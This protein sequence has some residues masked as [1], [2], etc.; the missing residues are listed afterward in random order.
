[1]RYSV[2]SGGRV[3]I[4][5]HDMLGREV[6]TILEGSTSGGEHS[7]SFNAGEFPAGIYYCR[8]EGMGAIMT[9][10]LVLVR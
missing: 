9:T 8:L 2:P 5:V 3:R 4:S 7:V 6:G 10:Q 1:L